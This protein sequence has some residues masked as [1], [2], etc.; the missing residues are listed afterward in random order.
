MK[1]KPSPAVTHLTD[2]LQQLPNLGRTS[3]QWLNAVGIRSVAQ[4]R[5]LGAVEAFRRVRA[6]G[7]NPSL[8]LLYG[9]DAA[10]RGIPWTQLDDAEKAVLRKRLDARR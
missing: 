9:L 5:E 6:R 7:L 4:L 3:V 1:K 10:L 2:D 8:A